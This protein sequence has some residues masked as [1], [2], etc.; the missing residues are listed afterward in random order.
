MKSLTQ[1]KNSFSA[2]VVEEFGF[3]AGEFKT[4][5]VN[6]ARV[7]STLIREQKISVE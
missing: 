7:V 5:L 3:E 2:Q 4:L 6:N 1:V